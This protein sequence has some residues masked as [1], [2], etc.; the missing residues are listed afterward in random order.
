MTKVE[1]DDQVRDRLRALAQRHGRNMGEEI[2]A[3]VELA[4]QADMWQGYRGA[5]DGLSPAIR[6]DSDAH[7]RAAL[8]A[9]TEEHLRATAR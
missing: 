6:S 8:L 4:E 9:A 3:L 2:A 1:I 5:M 7:A